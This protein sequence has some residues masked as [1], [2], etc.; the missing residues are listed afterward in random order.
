[1]KNKSRYEITRR[2]ANTRQALEDALREAEYHD[3]GVMPPTGRRLLIACFVG[4]IFGVFF[5]LTANY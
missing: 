5:M 2:S 3:A 1:M 4:V